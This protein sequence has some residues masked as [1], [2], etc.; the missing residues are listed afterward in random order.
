MMK[1]ALKD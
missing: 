1:V